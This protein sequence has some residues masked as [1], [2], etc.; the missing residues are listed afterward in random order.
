MAASVAVVQA[1]TPPATTPTVSTVAVTSNPGTDN[2]YTTLD[3]ITVTVTFSEAVTASGTPQITLDIGGTQ[4]TA[5]YAGPG[6]TTS[7]LLFSYEVQPVDQDGD[8]IA[9]VANSLA[10]NGGTIQSTDDSTDA[11]LTHAAQAAANH[12][13]DTEITLVSNL[14]QADGTA[15]R[16]SATQ[17]VRIDLGP[18]FANSFALREFVLDVKTPSDTLEVSVELHASEPNNPSTIY[19]FTGSATTAG[20]QT[21]KLATSNDAR[22]VHFDSTASSHRLIIKGSG[23]GYVELETTA[24]SDEDDDGIYGWALTA[25]HFST[26]GGQ[27]YV[28]QTPQLFPRISAVGHIK[29]VLGIESTIITSS[30]T[31]EPRTPSVKPLRSASS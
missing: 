21:F 10:L 20:L 13:V 7:R 6:T 14:G 29:Q 15:L 16:I 28:E 1:Q 24:S 5:G 23:G 26:D 19:Q 30:P 4:R 8:G 3:V 2:T 22:L 31:T 12:K 11:T 17:A 18:L 27:T 25:P 9:V